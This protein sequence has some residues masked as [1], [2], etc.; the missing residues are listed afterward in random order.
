MRLN[1]YIATAGIASRRKADELIKNGNVKVNGKAMLTLGYDVD[2]NDKVEVNGRR[3]LKEDVN[4]KKLYYVLNKPTGYVTSMHDEFDR[5][6]VKELVSDLDAR[7]FPVGRLDYNTSGLIIMTNDG[8][9]AY[10]LT[11]PKH[12]IYKKYLVLVSGNISA[13]KLS[14]LRKGVDIGDFVTSKAIVKVIKAVA[15]STLLEV[16]IHEGRNRQ[17]RKMFAAVGNRVNELK[18][19]AIGD[20]ELGHLKEG[21]FRKLR[22]DE[23]EKLMQKSRGV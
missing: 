11:H 10:K 8:D 18:R 23:L 13:E 7:L 19:V 9:F 2:E 22:P 16:Q 15:N 4:H 20:V 6:T 14:K 1:K 12:K 17:I 3:I 21:H 5:P